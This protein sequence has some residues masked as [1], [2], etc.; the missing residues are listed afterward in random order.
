MSNDH[1]FTA[2]PASKD[3]RRLVSVRLD[4][5]D[6]EVAVAGGG[7]ASRIP[8]RPHDRTGDRAHR[9]WPADD[10]AQCTDEMDDQRDRE[11]QRVRAGDDQYGHC[12]NNGIIGHAE[13]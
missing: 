6:L 3:E 13:Q 4:G 8:Q 11:P 9:R 12:A 5:R 2:Q 1:Y 7:D 10:L